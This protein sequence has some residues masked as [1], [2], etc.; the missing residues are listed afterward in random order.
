M[1]SLEDAWESPCL[2]A[3]QQYNRLVVQPF[4]AAALGHAAEGR[5][6]QSRSAAFKRDTRVLDAWMS[7]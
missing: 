5:L 3:L 4:L 1:L 6:R 7:K 2:T